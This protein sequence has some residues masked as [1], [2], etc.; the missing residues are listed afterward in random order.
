M[1]APLQSDFVVKSSHLTEVEAS[2]QPVAASLSQVALD[3][4]EALVNNPSV[5][6]SRELSLQI[7]ANPQIP[8]SYLIRQTNIVADHFN[9]SPS[10][11]LLR[12]LCYGIG[13]GVS[14]QQLIDVCPKDSDILS[15]AFVFCVK[16]MNDPKSLVIRLL[17]LFNL[18]LSPADFNID[19][20]RLLLNAGL[21]LD[22]DRLF[23][24]S[25]LL[26]AIKKKNA[27]LIPFLLEA[28]C[29]IATLFTPHPVPEVISFFQD[30][31]MITSE[32]SPNHK[33]EVIIKSFIALGAK[34]RT[35][36]P[37]KHDLLVKLLTRDWHMSYELAT[38]MG[39]LGF[40]LS[41]KRVDG[42]TVL[43]WACMQLDHSNPSS[44]LLVK[45]L[46]Q[47][48]FSPDE[49]GA[50]LHRPF[51]RVLRF[52]DKELVE[53]FVEYYVDLNVQVPGCNT[54]LH[55]VLA[56]F[57]SVSLRKIADRLNIFVVN[58]E[59]K[60]PVDIAYEHNASSF[61]RE[62]LT[63]RCKLKFP[64]GF[65]FSR[66]T[67]TALL[68]ERRGKYPFIDIVEA[69]LVFN[70]P[71][72]SKILMGLNP[73]K[74]FD[75]IQQLVTKHH[76]KNQPLLN[77]AYLINH[78]YQTVL[79]S[80]VNT[81]RHP[82]EELVGDLSHLSPVLLIQRV[83]GL[84]QSKDQQIGSIS[85]DWFFQTMDLIHVRDGYYNDL[86]SKYTLML[87]QLH[88]NIELL[89]EQKQAVLE[90]EMLLDRLH[91]ILGVTDPMT[92]IR[93]AAFKEYVHSFVLVDNSIGSALYFLNYTR[94]IKES[95][96]NVTAI[97]NG[98]GMPLKLLKDS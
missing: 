71:A 16:R 43:E 42:C 93:L 20:F 47:Y 46:I 97:L 15:E 74:Y 79:M 61:F 78:C 76:Y 17:S 12:L 65:T 66:E 32:M 25:P 39:Q 87:D 41:E 83:A 81:P 45:K 85:S 26:F 9:L 54:L 63:P 69:A 96:P 64:K 36:S 53:L 35:N 80:P 57:P 55:L 70:I 88:S 94:M 86:I 56:H 4:L 11:R 10:K 22:S 75:C 62:V 82:F 8:F 89:D 58:G 68:N 49:K 44:A 1:T 23:V 77:P 21:D 19:D 28:G 37:F 18:K 90:R 6:S 98:L 72:V 29:D 33:I 67:I 38:L 5:D 73:A 91:P 95:A 31:E 40:K 2:V 59:G 60:T 52:G 7:R 30:R 27:E 24:E 51:Q 14:M 48:H 84:I 34:L 3:S 13:A 92:I 50:D